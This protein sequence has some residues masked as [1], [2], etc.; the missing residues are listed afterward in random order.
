MSSAATPHV[1]FL[2]TSSPSI[3]RSKSKKNGKEIRMSSTSSVTSSAHVASP[4]PSTRCSTNRLNEDSSRPNSNVT[5]GDE[6]VA[7]RS[8][9]NSP[10]LLSPPS[11]PKRA[12]LGQEFSI[13]TGFF[14]GN[15]PAK[16]FYG[17]FNPFPYGLA[18]PTQ[19]I[20]QHSTFDFSFLYCSSVRSRRPALVSFQSLFALLFAV[21]FLQSRFSEHFEVGS[22]LV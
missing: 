10:L 4:S 5:S 18:T 21:A 7:G 14:S 6:D 20:D 22:N 8:R 16:R 11:T 1:S 17:C 19:L 2:S 9:V 3:S 12:S 15:C 13:R